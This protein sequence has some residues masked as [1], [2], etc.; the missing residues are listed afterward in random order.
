MEVS[1]LS[2]GA[3]GAS[4]P[5]GMRHATSARKFSRPISS[6]SHIMRVFWRFPRWP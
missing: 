2:S 5:E 1:I 4:S 6:M 3:S